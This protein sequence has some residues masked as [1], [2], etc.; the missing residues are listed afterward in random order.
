MPA[1]L[2]RQILEKLALTE[3][4]RREKG[5]GARSLWAMR[6]SPYPRVLVKGDG[7]DLCFVRKSTHCM[8]GWYGRVHRG[9]RGETKALRV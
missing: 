7:L 8:D 1:S 6:G 4:R 5:G 2:V 9:Y 3:Q